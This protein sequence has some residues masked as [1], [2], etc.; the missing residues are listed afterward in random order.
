MSESTDIVDFPPD[1]VHE[2]SDYE[3][4]DENI[5]KNALPADVPG[6]LEVHTKLEHSHG[7]LIFDGTAVPYFSRAFAVALTPI[8]VGDFIRCKLSQKVSK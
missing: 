6:N 8:S 2:V 3:Y 5:L 4:I 7:V 1:H